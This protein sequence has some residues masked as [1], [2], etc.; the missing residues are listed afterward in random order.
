VFVRQ[1]MGVARSLS[2]GLGWVGVK[3]APGG[4][5]QADPSGETPS[6]RLAHALV[7]RTP[8]VLPVALPSPSATG[9]PGAGG[10][11][12][13][14]GAAGPQ[15]GTRAGA[16]DRRWWAADWR[17]GQQRGTRR[18]GRPSPRGDDAAEHHLDT[19]LPHWNKVPV[20]RPAGSIETLLGWCVGYFFL[21]FGLRTPWPWGLCAR[22]RDASDAAQSRPQSGGLARPGRAAGSGAGGWGAM[23]A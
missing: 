22:D 11:L 4:G 10:A 6:A 16:A 23:S 12:D 19:S 18:Q 17:Q 20:D 3:G 5:E 9:R 21:P 8:Y 1:P 14:R 15:S 7:R 13:G 2:V